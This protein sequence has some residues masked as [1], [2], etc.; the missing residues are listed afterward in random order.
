METYY[1]E[2]AHKVM[3]ADKSYCKLETWESLWRN[4]VWL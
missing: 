2:L 3:A 4:S 1:K